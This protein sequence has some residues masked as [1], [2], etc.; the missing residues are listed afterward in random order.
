[1][2]NDNA[3]R[4]GVLNMYHLLHEHVIISNMVFISIGADTDEYTRSYD[5]FK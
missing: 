3:V 5:K 4:I 2:K 1:M